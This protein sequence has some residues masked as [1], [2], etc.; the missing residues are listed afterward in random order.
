MQ[1]CTGLTG[2]LYTKQIIHMHKQ[3]IK[4]SGLQVPGCVDVMS[5]W[6]RSFI[7]AA[8]YVLISLV[9]WV[10][11]VLAVMPCI[12][13]NMNGRGYPSVPSISRVSNDAV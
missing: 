11:N 5:W 13:I 2:F 8:L 1:R 9:H 4:L 6:S 7:T 10:L 12:Q 3:F